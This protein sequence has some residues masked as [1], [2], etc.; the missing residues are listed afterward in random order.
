MIAHVRAAE[1]SG[2]API[3]DARSFAWFRAG[4]AH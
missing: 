2:V 3:M 4:R 1:Q